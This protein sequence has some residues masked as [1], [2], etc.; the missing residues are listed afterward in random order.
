MGVPE[1][2]LDQCL[3]LVP[4][5]RYKFPDL[6]SRSIYFRGGVE[7]ALKRLIEDEFYEVCA[8][9]QDYLNRTEEQDTSTLY[10]DYTAIYANIILCEV[11]YY[12]TLKY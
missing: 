6:N 3:V 7:K 9:L 8:V 12:T 1:G 5:E 2:V 11:G 4:P 10:F